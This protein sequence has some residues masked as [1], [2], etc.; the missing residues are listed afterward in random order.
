M[1]WI[2]LIN[3][4]VWNLFTQSA[5]LLIMYLLYFVKASQ[6]GGVAFSEVRTFLE[7]SPDMV[8]QYKSII[9]FWNQSLSLTRN[10]LIY[11]RKSFTDK[12][13]PM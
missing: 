4:N 11:A 5:I 6:N 7:K 3:N 8:T 10:H 13:N 1:K 2:N 12:F 9:T